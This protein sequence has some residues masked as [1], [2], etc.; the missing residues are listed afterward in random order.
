[1]QAQR[2][3]Q[4]IG[5]AIAAAAGWQIQVQPPPP[6]CVVIG[7]PHTSNWDLPATLLLMLAANLRLRWVGKAVLFRGPLGWLMRA[8]GGIPVDRSARGNFVEQMVD[9]F[10]ASDALMIAILPEGTRRSATHW[11]TGFYYIA[12]SAGVPIVLGYADYSRRVVGLGPALHPT[13]DIQ[14]DFEI[15]RAFYAGITGKHPERQSAIQIR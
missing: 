5:L 6:R 12:L 2:V 9:A 15:I 13:G 8:L 11:K 1:M 4:R 3:S 14:A 10:R 7:A